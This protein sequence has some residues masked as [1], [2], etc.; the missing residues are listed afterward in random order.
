MKG[1]V[2]ITSNATNSPTVITL[3]GT[4]LS[5]TS[6][7]PGGVNS[8]GAANS[9]GVAHSVLLSW[10]PSTS[11]DVVGYNVY[12]AT[13]PGAAYAKLGNSAGGLNYTD[14]TAQSGQTYTY[15]VTAVDSVGDESVYSAS[16]TA[17]IP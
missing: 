4:A 12:R 6:G 17:A 16:V 7:S 5:Q 1:S 14:A 2:K 13:S 11:S 3:N 8:P 15:V 9:P 10:N